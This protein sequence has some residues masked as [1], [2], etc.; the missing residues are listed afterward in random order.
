MSATANDFFVANTKS[1]GLRALDWVYRF[2][3]EMDSESPE[4]GG[5]RSNY[6]RR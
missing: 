2:A 3:Q 6:D 4:C 5:I 1:C